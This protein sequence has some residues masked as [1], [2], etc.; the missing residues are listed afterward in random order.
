MRKPFISREN[1][2][3]LFKERFRER[4]VMT[5]KELL[6]TKHLYQSVQVTYD[7]LSDSI[8]KKGVQV[9][10]SNLKRDFQS[11]ICMHW[12]PSDHT[13][14]L[15]RP[16]QSDPDSLFFDPPDVKLFCSTCDRIEAFN[17]VFADDYLNRGRI[18]PE[19]F[20]ENGVIV[21]GFVLSYL[22]QSCKSVPEVCTIRRQ[23]EKLILCGRAP[24]EKLN[25]PKVIPKKVQDFYRGA[26]LAHH[27]RQTLAGLFLL[28][29]TIEQWALSVT[30]LKDPQADKV[31]DEYMN[32]L[33]DDFKK[34][35][36]SM[37]SLYS[38][39]SSDIHKAEGSEELFR[40]AIKEIEEHFEARRLFKI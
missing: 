3:T 16:M 30:G 14:P 34:R 21:Q 36:P 9:N 8:I 37:R 26:L 25:I 38:K 11:I 27:S 22:C 31:L 18:S 5:I 33:P 2:K 6:E 32:K 39:L 13:P 20:R 12:E 23:G 10:E 4:I 15:I 28:R 17:P 1:A 19:P 24:M 35:F 40:S 7:D 29:T